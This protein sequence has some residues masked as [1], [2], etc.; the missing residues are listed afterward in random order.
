MAPSKRPP[1]AARHCGHIRGMATYEG[2]KLVKMYWVCV[3]G[4]GHI[5]SGGQSS[6]G[7]QKRGTTVYVNNFLVKKAFLLGESY[8]N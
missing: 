7:P 2:D 3:E 4:S 5:R 1:E 8:F 6:R